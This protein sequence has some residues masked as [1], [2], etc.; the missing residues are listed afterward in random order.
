MSMADHLSVV[1]ADY[2]ATELSV[3]PQD[4]LTER[5]AN[6]QIVYRTDGAGLSVV[7]KSNVI[8]FDVALIWTAL[9]VTDAETI[10]DFYYSV[11]KANRMARTFYWQHP[12]DDETYT[13]RFTSELQ[14]IYK[15]NMPNHIGIGRITLQVI[16]KKE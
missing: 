4:T 14:K 16:G 2:T 13:A 5:V 9:T 1:A 10:E 12:K 11:G 6:P 7:S 3:T 8:L 15:A